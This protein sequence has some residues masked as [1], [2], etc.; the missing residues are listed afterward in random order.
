MSSL[1]GKTKEGMTMRLDDRFGRPLSPPEDRY[2]EDVKTFVTYKCQWCEREYTED[3]LLEVS[4][5]K[6]GEE[7]TSKVCPFCF[8]E[9]LDAIETHID[10]MSDSEYEAYLRD[11]REG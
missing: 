4:Y 6:D 1:H 5:R 9:M 2:D 7:V 3:E 8:R 10:V 11:F